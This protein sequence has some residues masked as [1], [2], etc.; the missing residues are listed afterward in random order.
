MLPDRVAKHVESL[1]LIRMV[2]VG[3]EYRVFVKED[4]GCLRESHMMLDRIASGFHPIPLERLTEILI[5]IVAHTPSSIA[6]RG[7]SGFNFASS[8]SISFDRSSCTFG[9]TTFTSTI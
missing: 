5:D 4:R 3:L 7:S 1:L 6:A 9:T 8:R 2:G